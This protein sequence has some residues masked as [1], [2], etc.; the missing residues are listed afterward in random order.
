MP[1][2]KMCA[3]NALVNGLLAKPESADKRPKLPLFNG[4]KFLGSGSSARLQGAW[5][6]LR[7]VQAEIG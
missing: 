3:K 7:V 6:K 1:T 5:K 4:P 2:R